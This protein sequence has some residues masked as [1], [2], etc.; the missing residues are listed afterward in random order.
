VFVAANVLVVPN[1]VPAKT[2]P[3]LVALAR[4]QPGKLTY[5]HAGAGTS[6][7]LAA[8]LFKSF[9]ASRHPA[10]GLPRHDRAAARLLAGRSPC[11]SERRDM[12]PH[13]PPREIARFRRDLAQSDRG[14]PRSA[15][16]AR[17]G[18]PGFEAVP[19]FGLM[20][21]SGTPAR[22]HRQATRHREKSWRCP[23]RG[24]NS[25]ISAWTPSATRREFA[26]AIERETPQWA[27]VIKQAGIR[28]E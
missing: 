25:T 6:Q 10:R 9:G 11:R 23:T 15:D 24:K 14:S 19:W 18:Y 27:R 13:G 22:D 5:A 1:E 7:Q 3:E 2:L 21:P 8:E 20:A 28:A 17:S 16:H 12:L 26:A 4:A